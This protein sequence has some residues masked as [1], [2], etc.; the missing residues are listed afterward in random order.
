LIFM[1][2][3]FFLYLVFQALWYLYAVGKL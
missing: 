2:L 1:I 3:V